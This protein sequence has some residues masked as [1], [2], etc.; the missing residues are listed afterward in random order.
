ML[1]LLA[2]ASFALIGST[3]AANEA[4]DALVSGF[5]NPPAAA[6]PR[7]WWHWMNGNITQEGIRLDMEWMHRV[8]IGG[9]QNF[10][11]AFFTPELVHPRLVYMTPA[12]QDAFRFA[13]T[14][15]DS[16]GLELSVA[17]SPGWS[18]SG[19]PWVKP[20]EAMK[21][22][23]WS[24]TRIAGG[25]AFKGILPQPPATIGPIQ[26]VPIDRN[27]PTAGAN[28][29]TPVTPL[30]ADIAVIA[31]KLPDSDHDLSELRPAVS[32]SGGAIEG[33]MLWDGD[34]VRTIA[35]PFAAKDQTAWLQY[36]FDTAQTVHAMT[37][38]FP[39][40]RGSEFFVDR[41]LTVATLESS[42]NGQLYTKIVDVKSST[43]VE[44]TLAFDPVKA[45]YFRLVLAAPPPPPPPLPGLDLGAPPT[46]HRV[47]EWV[48]HTGARVNLAED[49]AA[50]FVAP[51][52]DEAATPAIP[53]AA[54]IR[55]D[56]ILDLTSRLQ[57]NGSLQW[58][59]PPGRW[60]VLRFG[61][62]LLGITNHPASPEGTG[63][64]VDKLSRQHVQSS[65]TQYLDK[66]SGFLGADL[67]GAKGLHGM[68]NDSW[69]AGAQNWTENLPAE[70][71]K[72]RGYA[73]LPWLPA[74]AGRVIGSAEDTDKFLWDF[75]ETLGDMLAEYHYQTIAELLHQ[76]GMIH[77]SESHES[78]RAFIGDGMA[79]KRFADVPMSAMWAGGI[80]PQDKYDADIRESASVAHLY[81]RNLVAAESFTAAGDTFAYTPEMLKPTA[82]RELANG[83]NRFVIH[84]SVHQPLNDP[85]PGF[86]LGPF[87]QWFTR[88]ESWAEQAGP[89]VSYL[90]R[91]AYLLQQGQFVADILYFY[92]EDSNLTQLFGPG[93]P[94]IPAGYNFDFADLQ[95][96]SLLSVSDGAL[97]TKSG[98]RYQVLALDPRT[99][100]MSLPALNRLSDLAHAGAILMGE[101]PKSSPSRAD[102]SAAFSATADAL[103]GAGA[104]GTPGEHRVGRGKVINVAGWS[105]LQ[106]L[107][108]APDFSFEPAAGDTKVL[109]VHRHLS[110]GDLYFVNNRLGRAEKFEASFRVAGKAPEL[111]HADTGKM[112]P[113]SYRIVAGR[114]LVP[115]SLDAADAVFV[116]FRNNASQPSLTLAPPSRA[117][118]M[119]LTGA[120]TLRFPAGQ[121]APPAIQIPNLESWTNSS[122]PGVKYFS[123]SARY[124]HSLEI[125]AA[126]LRNR[127]QIELDLG[128]VKNIAEIWVNGKSLGVLWKAPFRIDVTG[129]VHAGSN[130]LEVAVTNTWVNRLIGDKQPDAKHYATT[131]F[132]PYR[133]DSPLLDSGL[134]G[135]VQLIGVGAAK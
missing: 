89:W 92:G 124:A 8:G 53:A 99:R 77:Y 16:L 70:F 68:V 31:F 114:T 87:G 41:N 132:D 5:I 32:S 30:Y 112:E 64:E 108:I 28:T 90:G 38:V 20:I 73:L 72:R 69:E 18:E 76:H 123:G 133:A 135:P 59:P 119:T 58:T 44:Q 98:M 128:S 14:T 117:A 78:G 129:A 127:Q 83:L 22:V 67:M 134:L 82:D 42:E 118:L 15:A 48:L 101:K 100:T 25:K 111:W 97:T 55:P 37:L 24:E 47:S 105:S 19:G 96:L 34:L 125:P 65:Y 27:S 21:K 3:R 17:G 85:G 4:E 104:D 2:A 131:T 12:W 107:G 50:F 79:V 116:V 10:D 93:L 11:A 57:P 106:S 115:L 66:F 86:T 60:T 26:N 36:T 94:A 51:S 80:G 13:A 95:A 43:D 56:Q 88:H 122:D 120:W 29:A 54:A 46:E 110:N 9:V 40:A 75:R 7:V 81:G 33:S 62:S 49:K 6:K 74:L 39:S 35:V 23:V 109:F 61:Y 103:W 1:T 71:A 121:A 130:R 84:T 102:D 126:W 45:R 52:L 91:S 63:L 113:A